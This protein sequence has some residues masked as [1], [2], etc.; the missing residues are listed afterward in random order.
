MKTGSSKYSLCLAYTMVEMLM[1]MGVCG[2]VLSGL[3]AGS[4]ALQ[5]SFAA[6][7]DYSNGLNDQMRISDYLAVD[8]RRAATIV[9]DTTGGIT[10][11]LPNYYNSDGTINPPTVTSTMGWPDKKRKKKKNKHPNILLSKATTYGAV[12]TTTVKYYKGNAAALGKDTT[13]F[14]R[15]SAGVAKAIASDVADFAL[16]IS[17]DGDYAT[18]R[19]RFSPRFRMLAT[20][21]G[22][23]A[24]TILTQTILLRNTD[25]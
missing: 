20:N 9:P 11:T 1:A 23:N 7:V 21:S 12:S 16:T 4:V 14:Y 19:I 13:K 22:V 5:R 2:M 17:N 18:T 8:M 15:E 3:L 6:T 24:G 10:L 25:E